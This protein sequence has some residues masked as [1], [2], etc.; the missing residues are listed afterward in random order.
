M[1]LVL[2]PRPV[3][4]LQRYLHDPIQRLGHSRLI[5]ALSNLEGGHPSDELSSTLFS[6]LR[7]LLHRTIKTCLAQ[8][9]HRLRHLL[10]I[11]TCT[12]SGLH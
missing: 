12:E 1:L 7:V 3:Q 9:V 2:F 8:E 10:I 11:R 6:I 4:L 5:E